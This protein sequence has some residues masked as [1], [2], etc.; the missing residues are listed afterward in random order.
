MTNE[1]IQKLLSERILIEA[2]SSNIFGMGYLI[3]QEPTIEQI[4]IVNITLLVTKKEYETKGVALSLLK[5][6]KNMLNGRMLV[7]WADKNALGFYK[8]TR[9]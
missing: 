1:T 3:Y 9:I 8:K 5:Y 2:N 4:P 6:I 7:V